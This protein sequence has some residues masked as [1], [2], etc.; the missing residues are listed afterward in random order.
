MPLQDIERK[1]RKSEMALLA[2]RSQE[3]AVEMERSM[4]QPHAAQSDF[5]Y[6][7]PSK[8]MVPGETPMAIPDSCYNEDGEPDIRKMTGNQAV[9]FM[10][11]AGFNFPVVP[12]RP[13]AKE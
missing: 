6:G 1:F 9:A 4:K 7:P 3:Q 11:A 10:R 2:W 13:R 12:G 5:K 8:P